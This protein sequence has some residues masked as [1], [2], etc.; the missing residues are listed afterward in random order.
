[1][2]YSFRP[3]ASRLKY[4]LLSKKQYRIPLLLK[5][6][7]L[8]VNAFSFIKPL[9]KHSSMNIKTFHGL[10]GTAKTIYP[11]IKEYL[12]LIS[13]MLGS[14]S[15]N[16]ELRTLS[17]PLD[18]SLDVF[19]LLE[20]INY[21]D[22]PVLYSHVVQYICKEIDLWDNQAHVKRFQ[23][24]PLSLQIDLLKHKKCLETLLRVDDEKK[25]LFTKLSDTLDICQL[26]IQH[27]STRPKYG[28][29]TV[30][31][32]LHERNQ[33][34]SRTDF[35]YFCGHGQLQ[36]VQYLHSLGVKGTTNDIVQASENGHLH[37]VKYLHSIGRQCSP[38]AMD[39]ASSNGHLHI[40]KYLHSIGKQCTTYAMD[41]ASINGHLSVVK[42]LH[43]I[44]KQ[45]SPNAIVWARENGHD[46]V[47]QYLRSIQ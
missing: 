27:V 35:D 29:L 31:Y 45:C 34:C 32:L 46:E 8:Y 17:H 10:L 15:K 4:N 21:L 43:S 37:I 24:L 3:C 22:I 38:Y 1:M 36:I 40:V 28:I 25:T 11:D 2:S 47:V 20:V 23:S 9:R 30:K 42:Y 26:T 44:G 5:H 41:W 39:W 7:Q 14:V 13:Q 16:E 6:S 12:P 19:R 33:V 18:S